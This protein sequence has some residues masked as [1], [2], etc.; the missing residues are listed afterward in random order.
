VAGAGMCGPRGAG[1]AVALARLIG[2]VQRPVLAVAA[3]AVEAEAFAADLRFLLGAPEGSGPLGRRV[4]HLPAWEIPPFE[5]LSPT[6]E[7][8]VARAEGLYHLQ[9]STAPIVLTT[10]DSSIHRVPPPPP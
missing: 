10:V 4:H 6:R 7:T 8:L 5:P 1:R 3:S 9:Q 2:S